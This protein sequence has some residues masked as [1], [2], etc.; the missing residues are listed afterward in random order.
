MEQMRELKYDAYDWS[1]SSNSQSYVS[2]VTQMSLHFGDAAF[3]SCKLFFGRASPLAIFLFTNTSPRLHRLA[4]GSEKG[5]RKRT[6]AN[7]TPPPQTGA[8]F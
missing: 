6:K 7:A 8:A 2:D 4:T 3:R 5:L 1:I